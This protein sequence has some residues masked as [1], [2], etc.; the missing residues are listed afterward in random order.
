[1]FYSQKE[2]DRHAR[3]AVSGTMTGWKG[4][5][6]QSEGMRERDLEVQNGHKVKFRE[7]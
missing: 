3:A 5:K 4:S 2:N 1:M 6:H 7:S